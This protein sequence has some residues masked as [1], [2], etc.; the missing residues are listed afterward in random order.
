MYH[1]IGMIHSSVQTTY[2][3]VCVY[4]LVWLQDTS[5]KVVFSTV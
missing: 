5:Q 1:E 4:F 3:C 2:M